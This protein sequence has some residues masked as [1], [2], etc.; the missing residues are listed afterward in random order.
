ME[1]G[2]AELLQVSDVHKWFG[3]LHVLKG[4]SFSVKPGECVAIIGPSGSG[5]STCLRTINY[6]EPPGQGEIRLQGELIGQRA[7]GGKV[8]RRMSDTE[9][10]PQRARI[11]M[12][13]QLFHLW[14]HL[15]ALQNVALQ[16]RKV[17]GMSQAKA[18]AVAFEMLAKVHLKEKA[19]EYPDRLSGGQQQRVAIARVLAQNP[20]LILFDEPTSA[21][22][23]ELVGEVLLVIQELAKERRAMV[24]VTHEIAF[25][26]RVADRIIFMDGG[27]IVEEGPP[28]ALLD[29]PKSPRLRKFL[30]Q[31][32]Q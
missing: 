5:K 19:D 17:G 30:Q 28:V 6:L 14:P 10:S 3:D 7:T 16:P 1:T 26:R 29:E 21:L 11:G 9:L 32:K 8:P 31:M 23:P 2:T 15:T 22:D 4:V 24:L 27:L 18:S 13:F 12:V 20:E 25:A